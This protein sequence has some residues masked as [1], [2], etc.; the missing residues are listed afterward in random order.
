MAKEREMKQY[1]CSKSGYCEINIITRNLCKSCRFQKCLQVGM[2]IE[3]MYRTIY[4]IVIDYAMVI[5]V[6]LT[7]T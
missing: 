5:M 3:G 4:Y 2:S 1:Q 7:L 6:I